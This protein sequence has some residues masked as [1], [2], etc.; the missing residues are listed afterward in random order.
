MG[1]GGEGCGVKAE[2]CEGDTGE[3]VGGEGCDEC[4]SEVFEG[5]DGC[6][7]E[8]C[9]EVRSNGVRGIVEL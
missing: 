1:V 6:W 7:N 4:R 8:C 2:G 5:C 3:A 9:E